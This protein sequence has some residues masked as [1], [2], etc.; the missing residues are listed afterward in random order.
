MSRKTDR[1]KYCQESIDLNDEGIQYSDG[2]CA[3]EHCD[4]SQQFQNANRLDF[5]DQTMTK[6]EY[7]TLLEQLREIQDP[8]IKLIY[9]DAGLHYWDKKVELFFERDPDS[10]DEEEQRAHFRKLTKILKSAKLATW[11]VDEYGLEVK[12]KVKGARLEQYG[13]GTYRLVIDD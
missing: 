8:E 11:E 9:S 3:H 13:F 10:E 7:Q 12:V 4:D 1:C 5:D 2:S 6:N